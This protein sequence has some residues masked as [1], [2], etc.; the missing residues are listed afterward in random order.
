MTYK[1]T[2]LTI[3]TP[4][5]RSSQGTGRCEGNEGSIFS[6]EFPIKRPDQNTQPA[7]ETVGQTEDAIPKDN[8]PHHNFGQ[9]KHLC[10]SG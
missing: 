2:N 5:Y 1:P 6:P 10:T 9:A 3:V 7:T 4:Y 8:I